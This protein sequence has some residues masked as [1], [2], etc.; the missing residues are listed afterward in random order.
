[1]HVPRQRADGPFIRHD[2]RRRTQ[3]RGIHDAESHKEMCKRASP[4]IFWLESL[5][6]ADYEAIVMHSQAISLLWEDE[7]WA[8]L[9]TPE[10]YACSKERTR[11]Y[12]RGPQQESRSR[13]AGL[14]RCHDAMRY[15]PQVRSPNAHAALGIVRAASSATI[16]A[17]HRVG[18]TVEVIPR[19]RAAPPPERLSFP[20]PRCARADL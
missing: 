1:M 2:P 7:L 19:F 3:L 12:G 15:V 20:A 6:K 18:S 14:C 17:S 13:N 10:Y 11:N 4:P 5:A 8:V 16:A 9:K